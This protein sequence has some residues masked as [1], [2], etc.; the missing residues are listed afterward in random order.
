MTKI[1]STALFVFS[2]FQASVGHSSEILEL[3]PTETFKIRG[4][5]GLRLMIPT[6]DQ[7]YLIFMD[8]APARRSVMDLQ[9]HEVIAEIVHNNPIISV[10][11]APNGKHVFTVDS[12][13]MVE[14]TSTMTWKS[15]KSITGSLN[16]N[17]GLRNVTVDSR[18]LIVITPGVWP[19]WSGPLGQ[20][21]DMNTGEILEKGFA[22]D[23]LSVENYVEVPSP[24]ALTATVNG[25]T[26]ILLKDSGTGLLVGQISHPYSSWNGLPVEVLV[27]GRQII[28][29]D[30]TEMRFTPF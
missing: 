13:G 19:G 4:Y 24:G 23:D 16:P 7:K 3:Q 11:L 14:M 26:H 2:M 18:G 29:S 20:L 15:K 8:N 6:L 1:L 9:T 21:I 27:V 10:I 30:Y 25:K 28:S 17:V 12:L 5:N 22:A